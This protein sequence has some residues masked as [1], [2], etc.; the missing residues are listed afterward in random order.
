MLAT[1]C[2][3]PRW[4]RFSIQKA[5]GNA[6]ESDTRRTSATI[7]STLSNGFISAQ[8]RIGTLPPTAQQSTLDSPKTIRD[9][10]DQQLR[11]QVDDDTSRQSPSTENWPDAHNQHNILRPNPRLTTN[12]CVKRDLATT[13]KGTHG[14]RRF[15]LGDYA[16]RD[17]LRDEMGSGEAEVECGPNERGCSMPVQICGKASTTPGRPQHKVATHRCVERVARV[18]STGL[19]IADKSS[20]QQLTRQ[21]TSPER[22]DRTRT[23]STSITNSRRTT[24]TSATR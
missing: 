21:S 12:R 5:R 15:T 8:E 22:T 3:R 23:I 6:A 17:S 20:R 11:K 14:N 10:Q 16:R 9:K 13:D 18:L 24:D 4:A 7:Q 2:N 19:A 1:R